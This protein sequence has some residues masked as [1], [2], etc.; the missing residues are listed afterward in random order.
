MMPSAATAPEVVT[1]VPHAAT[2]TLPVVAGVITV[3]PLERPCMANAEVLAG[4]VGETVMRCPKPEFAGP[5]QI[6]VGAV[7]VTRQSISVVDP[8]IVFNVGAEPFAQP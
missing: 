3:A 4:A 7:V 8:G 5:R 1:I 6:K 2:W